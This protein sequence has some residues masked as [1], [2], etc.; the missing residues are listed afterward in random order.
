MG[1]EQTIVITEVLSPKGGPRQSPAH[2]TKLG[3]IYAFNNDIR[4]KGEPVGFINGQCIVSAE[5]S[6]GI[7]EPYLTCTE[8]VVFNKGEFAN[9]SLTLSGYFNMKECPSLAIVGGTG[10]FKYA[11]GE[12]TIGADPAGEPMCVQVTLSFHCAGP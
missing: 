3:E 8:S 11:S 6:P 9:S 4:H 7:S 5:V 12:A 10:Q 2:R 1:K